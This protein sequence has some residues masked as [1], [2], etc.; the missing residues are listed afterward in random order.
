[1]EGQANLLEA[2]NSDKQKLQIKV[3]DLNAPAFFV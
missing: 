2:G 3:L 1:M